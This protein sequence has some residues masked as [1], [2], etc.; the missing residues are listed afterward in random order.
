MGQVAA[1]AAV[2]DQTHARRSLQF[3]AKERVRFAGELAIMPGCTVLPTYANFIFLELPR[4]WHAAAMAARLKR[5]GL[6][7]RD[8]SDMPGAGGQAIRVAVRSR[9]DND[10]LVRTL[11]GALRQGPG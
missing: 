8:C 11:A 6:L 5:D 10:R 2:Q 7:I 1:L 3:I 4:G 9:R